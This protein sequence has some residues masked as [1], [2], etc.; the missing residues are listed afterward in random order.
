MRLSALASDAPKIGANHEDNG[1]RAA[2]S[3]QHTLP[4]REAKDHTPDIWFVESGE[5][6]PA[7][8]SQSKE[9]RRLSAVLRTEV[10]EGQLTHARRAYSKPCVSILSDLAFSLT[11]RMVLSGIPAGTV[12]SR[13]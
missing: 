7:M 4:Y 1:A 11:V 12:T 6:C 2:V 3:R 8:C 5:V 10:P 13:V 9:G